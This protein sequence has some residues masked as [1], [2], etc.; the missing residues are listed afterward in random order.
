M[1]DVRNPGFLWSGISSSGSLYK[2]QVLLVVHGVAGKLFCSVVRHLQVPAGR[3][4]GYPDA[5]VPFDLALAA[6]FQ[7]GFLAPAGVGRHAELRLLVKCGCS[8]A[9]TS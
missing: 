2:L 1:F 3:N 6:S 5:A 8:A 7:P 4:T 9:A